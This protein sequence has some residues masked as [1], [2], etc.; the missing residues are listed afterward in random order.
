MSSVRL[1]DPL[2]YIKFSDLF[3]AHCQLGD[4]EWSTLG[5]KLNLKNGEARFQSKANRIR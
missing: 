5:G 3:L 4:E 1:G 2:G